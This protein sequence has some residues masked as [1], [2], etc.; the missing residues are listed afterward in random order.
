MVGN[1]FDLAVNAES[2]A[3]Q[4]GATNSALDRAG[5]PY[6][7]VVWDSISHGSRAESRA[8]RGYVETESVGKQEYSLEDFGPDIDESEDGYKDTPAALGSLPD[9]ISDDFD[10]PRYRRPRHIVGEE[11]MEIGARLNFGQIER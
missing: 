1:L 7:E 3:V 10:P 5:V 9:Q 2:E 4:L 8:A 11:A 6:Q